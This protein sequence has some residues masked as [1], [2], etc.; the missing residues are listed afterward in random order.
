MYYS[1]TLFSE[2]TVRIDTNGVET[3]TS[4]SDSL[5]TMR[6]ETAGWLPGLP[7]VATWKN[8]S[9]GLFY[10][11]IGGWRPPREESS[12]SDSVTPSDEP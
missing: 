9:Q 6:A 10:L 4:L 7:V 1:S 11:A 2:T 3:A 8:S 12:Q 5:E